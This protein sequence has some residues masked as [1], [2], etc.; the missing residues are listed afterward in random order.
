VLLQS[1]SWRTRGTVP[2]DANAKLPRGLGELLGVHAE[3]TAAYTRTG[4]G[5]ADV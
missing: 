2:G 3:N 4:C 1:I 5:E